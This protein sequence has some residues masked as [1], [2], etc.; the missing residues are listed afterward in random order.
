[1]Q[2]VVLLGACFVMIL[3]EDKLHDVFE[4][5]GYLG[6]EAFNPRI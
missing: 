3:Y 1:M 5:R 6:D 2:T 4:M